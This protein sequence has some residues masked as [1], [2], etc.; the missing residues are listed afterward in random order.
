MCAFSCVNCD[1]LSKQE[2]IFNLWQTKG[3]YPILRDWFPFSYVMGRDWMVPR[4]V[5]TQ[6]KDTSSIRT[7]HRKVYVVNWLGS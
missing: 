6:P 7:A 5:L 3:G 1:L 2:P 4:D